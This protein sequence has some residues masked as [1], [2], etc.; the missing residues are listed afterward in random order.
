MTDLISDLRA[1]LPD[2]TV[3]TEPDI[4]R[5]Y[6][7][8]EADLCE[9]GTPAAVVRPRTTGEVCTAVRIAGRH[10]VPVVPQGARTGL[11]GAANATDGALILSLAGMSRILEIDT[12]NRI[13]VVQPGVVNAALARAVAEHGLAYPPDPGSWELSTIGGNVATNAGGMCCV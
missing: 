9:H 2:G 3:L 8:D 13:A 5:S 1:A 4:L 12:V 10:R 7:R 6:E 11:A